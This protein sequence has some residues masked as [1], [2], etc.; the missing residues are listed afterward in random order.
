[1]A[2]LSNVIKQLEASKILLEASK[3]PSCS[4]RQRMQMATNLKKELSTLKVK[5]FHQRHIRWV[6]EQSKSTR[7]EHLCTEVALALERTIEQT[8][9]FQQWA[10]DRYSNPKDGKTLALTAIHHLIASFQK[11]EVIPGDQDLLGEPNKGCVL[12]YLEKALELVSALRPVLGSSWYSH[13]DEMAGHLESFHFDHTDDY[14]RAGN[15]TL[16]GVIDDQWLIPTNHLPAHR[17]KQ[18]LY[19]FDG[20]DGPEILANKP[21]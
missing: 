7:L 4:R 21:D 3:P 2:C 16:Q 1:M 14:K 5:K 20:L 15:P 10:S 17:G 19:R 12:H 6:Y 18:V 9:Y 8:W 11:F 13:C